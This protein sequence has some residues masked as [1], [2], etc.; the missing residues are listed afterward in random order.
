MLGLYDPFE[1]AASASRIGASVI[2]GWNAIIQETAIGFPGVLVV[3]TFDLFEGRED[4]L[5][6]DHF[7]PNRAG[8]SLITARVLQ[9]LP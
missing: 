7:H 2:L 9:G 6:L 8:Y 4:R 3:P 1:T 5:A